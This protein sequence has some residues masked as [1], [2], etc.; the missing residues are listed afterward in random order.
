MKT[1]KI[2]KYF[3]FGLLGG[4]LSHIGFDPTTWPFWIIVIIAAGIHITQII[5]DRG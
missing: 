2:I 3:L 4:T 5:E 1:S